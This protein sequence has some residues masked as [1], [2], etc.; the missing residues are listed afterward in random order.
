M[1]PSE[2][3]LS[4][5]LHISLMPTAPAIPSAHP[6]RR[7][8]KALE[9]HCQKDFKNKGTSTQKILHFQELARFLGGI[10]PPKQLY[11][12]SMV[13]RPED[14]RAE[15]EPANQCNLYHNNGKTKKCPMVAKSLRRQLCLQYQVLRPEDTRAAHKISTK[16]CGCTQLILLTEASPL[17]QEGHRNQAR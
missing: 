10:G 3:Y 4:G 9:Q 16:Q 7:Q 5:N 14:P 15:Q 13:L 11:L 8:G 1:C 6:R 2:L 12:Q 17:L